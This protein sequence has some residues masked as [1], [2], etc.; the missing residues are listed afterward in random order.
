MQQPF[1]LTM[2]SPIVEMDSLF[3]P[4][5]RLL[6]KTKAWGCD[7]MALLLLQTSGLSAQQFTLSGA[8]NSQAR[9]PPLIIGHFYAN[10]T[11]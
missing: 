8:H 4:L 2:Q 10:K 7:V 6:A 1:L 11:L 5:L 3:V 9:I